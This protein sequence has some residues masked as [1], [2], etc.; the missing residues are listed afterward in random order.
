M[1]T[2]CEGIV[3]ASL[4]PDVAVVVVVAVLSMLIY[5]CGCVGVEGLRGDDD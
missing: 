1:W 3:V 2:S 5:A 4:R